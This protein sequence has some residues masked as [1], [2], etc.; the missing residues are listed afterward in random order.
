[1]ENPCLVIDRKRYPLCD[2]RNSIDVPV[3]ANNMESRQENTIRMNSSQGKEIT[4]KGKVVNVYLLR[5]RFVRDKR[6]KVNRIYVSE[7]NTLAQWYLI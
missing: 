1:M 7:D 3:Y 2:V 4:L 5:C 6:G